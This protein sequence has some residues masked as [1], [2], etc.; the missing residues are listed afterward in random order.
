VKAYVKIYNKKDPV[1]G[2]EL[3]FITT[4][5]ASEQPIIMF[6]KVTIKTLNK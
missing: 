4:K 2:N 6:I 3:N 5:K 1:C